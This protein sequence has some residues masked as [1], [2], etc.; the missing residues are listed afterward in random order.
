M[1]LVQVNRNPSAQQ[2][3]EFGFGALIAL[4]V[5]GWLWG[6]SP[7]VMMTLLSLGL[8]CGLLGWIAPRV[9]KPVFIGLSLVSAPIGLVVSEI[10]LGLMFLLIFWPIG[11]CFRVMRRDGLKLAL[12]R[13]AQTYWEPKAQP[14]SVGSY[15][16]QW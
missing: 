11:L 14:R 7:P 1:K 5:V 12:I 15:Y 10:T 9:L 16:R 13:D 8:I 6:V 4:P 2:L 3:A